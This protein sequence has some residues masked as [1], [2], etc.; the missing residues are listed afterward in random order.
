MA[1]IDYSDIF[2]SFLGN[3]NDIKLTSLTISDAYSILTEYLHKSVFDPY[4]NRLFSSVSLDDE[5]QSLSYEMSYI[6]GDDNDR[7][8]VIN[9]IALW[10]VYRWWDQRVSSELLT[11]QFFGGKEQRW[12][13]Q[14]QHLVA[15]QASKDA[16]YKQARDFIRD[17][18]FVKN[19]YLETTS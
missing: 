9:A 7:E 11:A 17:R 19:T 16:A 15:L 14:Q 5:I 12:F 10:M 3:V 4:V 18:G 1:S 13:S 6:T 2:N 8:F